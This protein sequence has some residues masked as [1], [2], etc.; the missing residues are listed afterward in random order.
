MIQ[1]YISIEDFCKK[2]GK[3]LRLFGKGGMI[4]VT[5]A[6]QKVLTEWFVGKLNKYINAYKDE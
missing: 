3:S 6:R 5:K 2:V 1:D 4:D